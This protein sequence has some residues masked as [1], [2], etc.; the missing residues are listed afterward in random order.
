VKEQF[1][2]VPTS[3]EGELVSPDDWDGMG[4][5]REGEDGTNSVSHKKKPLGELLLDER[6]VSN[7]VME[8]LLRIISK[9]K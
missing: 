6:T 5:K 2:Q 9:A 4:E 8:E 3:L 1:L 7:S